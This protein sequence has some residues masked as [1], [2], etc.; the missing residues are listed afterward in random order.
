M[1]VRVN[2]VRGATN[3]GNGTAY[4]HEKVLPLLRQQAGY[5]GGMTSVDRAGAVVGLISLWEDK[6]ALEA[7]EGVAVDSR[8]EAVRM[9]GG[10]A[11]V[12][13]FEQVGG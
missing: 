6:N 5:R 8:A 9:I 2:T 11:T 12:D 13:T 4:L 1:H 10:D 3:P 7:S